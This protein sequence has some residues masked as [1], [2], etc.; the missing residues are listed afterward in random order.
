MASFPTRNWPSWTA[1]LRTLSVKPRLKLEILLCALPIILSPECSISRILKDILGLRIDTP[2]S[3]ILRRAYGIRFSRHLIKAKMNG[4]F[5]QIFSG[6]PVL[7]PNGSR[8]SW[9]NY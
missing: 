6:G 8:K 2:L 5:N 1:A 4:V 9:I 3:Q 7:W